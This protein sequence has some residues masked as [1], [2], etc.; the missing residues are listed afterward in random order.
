MLGARAHLCASFRAESGSIHRLRQ[1]QARRDM[2]PERSHRKAQAKIEATF[3]PKSP[4]TRY[5]SWSPQ[6][7]GHSPNEDVIRDDFDSHSDM[8]LSVW[9]DS[10]QTQSETHLRCSEI[11]PT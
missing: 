5:G 10:I 4:T 11:T 2:N 1:P 6:L 8:I 9:D 7:P 3:A